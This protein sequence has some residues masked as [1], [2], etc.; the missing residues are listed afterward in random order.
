MKRIFAFLI[1]VTFLGLGVEVKAQKDSLILVNQDIIAGSIKSMDRGV[2]TIETDYSKD[3]FRVKYSGIT[4][5]KTSTVFII[6]LTDGT[7]MSGSL[8]TSGPDKIKIRNDQ[9]EVREIGIKELVYIKLIEKDFKDRLSASVDFGFGVTKSQNLKQISFRS[10]VGYMTEDWSTD[11]YYN[12]IYSN[13]DGVEPIRNTDMGMTFRYLL[14]KDWYLPVSLT[15]LKNTQQK[16]DLRTLGRAGVGK[17]VIHTNH[18]YWGFAGGVTYNSENYTEAPDRKSWE[19]YIGT[20]LNL[21]DIGDLSL[22][23][24]LVVYPSLTESGRL[25]SDFNFDIKYDLPLDF[26]VKL[27]LTATYDNRP[28]AGATETDYMFQSGFGWKW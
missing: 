5:I 6:T 8:E 23:T 24:K 26:Y 7:R 19:G 16:I 2:V 14:P 1:T 22:Q 9:G 18:S 28:V 15:F 10:N 12:S 11:V 3:D 20:E 27:G 17:Y 13:Q 21:Y 25:R 4:R